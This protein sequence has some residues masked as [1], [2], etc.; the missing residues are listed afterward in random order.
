MQNAEIKAQ[1]NADAA[2][3]AF[4]LLPSS[5]V[6]AQ[7]T[8]LPAVPS[9]TL[10]WVM[11]VMVAMLLIAIAVY[12]AFGRKRVKLDDE[13]AAEIRKAAKRYNHDLCESR[14]ADLDRRLDGHDAEINSLWNTVRSENEAIRLEA[15]KTNERT[16]RALGRIEGRLGTNPNNEL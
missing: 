13:P 11:I 12:S 4:L 9:D 2:F 6:F 10:K 16:F 15:R 7:S 5:F 14:H 8:D 3:S 1:M